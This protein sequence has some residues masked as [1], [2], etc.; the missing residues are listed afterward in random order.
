MRSLY[1]A[2]RTYGWQKLPAM[3]SKPVRGGVIFSRTASC[4]RTAVKFAPAEVPLSM[5]PLRRSVFGFSIP[6]FVVS[7]HILSY[8]YDRE[9]K[10][11]SPIARHPGSLPVRKGM[12]F[13]EQGD[14]QRSPRWHE[15]LVLFFCKLHHLSKHSLASAVPR[16]FLTCRFQVLQVQILRRV[17]ISAVVDP[18]LQWGCMIEPQY[19][20]LLFLSRDTQRYRDLPAA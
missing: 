7:C 18:I 4:E 12:D 20:G 13:L 9:L 6:S 14:I 1:F 11:S 16:C 15:A 17:C 8:V 2:G 19:R 5:K 3:K 10:S